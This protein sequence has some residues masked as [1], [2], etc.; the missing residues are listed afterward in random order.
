MIFR[1][2]GDFDLLT[3]WDHFPHHLTGGAHLRPTT[4]Y[5][6]APR[7]DPKQ[8]PHPSNHGF[9]CSR[10][11]RSSMVVYWKGL[12]LRQ[13]PILYPRSFWAWHSFPTEALKLLAEGIWHEILFRGI[14]RAPSFD[15]FV[16][17]QIFS[18]SITKIPTSA[19]WVNSGRRSPF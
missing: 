12:F 2:L 8:A 6:Q 19:F 17:G 9:R 18:I 13:M 10:W 4:D 16:P 11:G 1:D 14:S 7:A 15:D 3:L 5:H